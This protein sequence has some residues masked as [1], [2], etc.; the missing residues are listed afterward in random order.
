MIAE[1]RGAPRENMV[2]L[3]VILAIDWVF[4]SC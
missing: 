4:Y 2:H 3:T 1:K